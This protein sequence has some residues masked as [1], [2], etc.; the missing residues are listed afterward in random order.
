MPTET[1]TRPLEFVDDGG[2]VLRIRFHYPD[3]FHALDANKQPTWFRPTLCWLV[4]AEPP[5]WHWQGVAKCHE[6][7][8]FCREKG[9]KIAL[10]YALE[11]G[12]F[13]RSERRRAWAAYF[14]RKNGS[15]ETTQ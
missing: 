14:A 13:N 3:D 2:E 9:R 4:R 11:N 6:S 8:Q 12:E 5:R 10:A 7:D 15:K 1:T